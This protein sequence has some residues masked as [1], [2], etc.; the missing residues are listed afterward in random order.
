MIS[1]TDV[2]R[3]IINDAIDLKMIMSRDK[4]TFKAVICGHSYFVD[5]N[6]SIINDPKG[7]EHAWA[8]IFMQFEKDLD[9]GVSENTER[10]IKL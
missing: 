6:D 9:K 1:A 4:I 10:I 3:K 7:I 5:L 8:N 2:G